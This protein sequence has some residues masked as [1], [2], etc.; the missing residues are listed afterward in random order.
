MFKCIFK[1]FTQRMNENEIQSYL[2]T[3]SAAVTQTAVSALKES[4]RLAK[5][6]SLL[7][8]LSCILY[9]HHLLFFICP[10][11]HGMYLKIC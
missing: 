11:E 8:I 7:K 5:L 4:S 1:K 9:S 10:A 2:Q 3:G 6:C